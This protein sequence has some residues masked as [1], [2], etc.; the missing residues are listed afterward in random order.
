M[1]AQITPDDCE[2]EHARL[3]LTQRVAGTPRRGQPRWNSHAH[4]YDRKE[5]ELLHGTPAYRARVSA[6]SGCP[7]R[8]TRAVGAALSRS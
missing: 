3:C 2:H 8:L 5:D 6:C 4:E 7:I 1:Q